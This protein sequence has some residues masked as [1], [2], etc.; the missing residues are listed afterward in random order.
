MV[1]GVKM[2]ISEEITPPTIVQLDDKTIGLIAA[3][4]VV[5]RPAQVV[6]ELLENSVDA[7][8]TRVNIEIQRG[9]FGL[10]GL[11]AGWDIDGSAVAAMGRDQQWGF[12]LEPSYTMPLGDTSKAG[13]FGRWNWYEF[14]RGEVDQYDAGINFW[15]VDNVVFK[16]AYSRIIPDGGKAEDVFNLVVGYSF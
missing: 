2:V 11:I 6:K 9:G 7:G 4:E 12:Y 8:S 10:R 5:E 16:A 3:G 1:G 13:I 15:P 14:A